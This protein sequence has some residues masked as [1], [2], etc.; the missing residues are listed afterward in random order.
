MP[1]KDITARQA[2][3][4]KRREDPKQIVKQLAAHKRWYEKSKKDPKKVEQ[5]RARWRRAARKRF[6]NNPAHLRAIIKKSYR[7]NTVK[8][9]ERRHKV[10]VTRPIPECCE[11][12]NTPFTITKR[13]P[14][15]DH[16]HVRQEFRG[17]LCANC[18]VTLGYAQDSRERLL[19]LVSYID[20]YELL[21]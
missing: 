21:R 3:E 2:H 6:A 1:Y 12:C 9:K 17:W 5:I 4:K 14:C 11:G 18:N 15:L 7:N 16:D 19:S 13:G 20:R 8:Y 10:T